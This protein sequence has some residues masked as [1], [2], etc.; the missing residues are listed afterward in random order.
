VGSST[1]GMGIQLAKKLLQQS[2]FLKRPLWT[3]SQLGQTWKMAVKI[4]IYVQNSS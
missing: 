4:D 3:T 1:A 2:P